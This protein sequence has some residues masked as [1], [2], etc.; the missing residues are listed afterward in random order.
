MIRVDYPLA[1]ADWVKA[2]GRRRGAR[3]AIDVLTG[4]R[5]NPNH[6]EAGRF[7]AS[8][9]S[10][11][12]TGPNDDTVEFVVLGR[13]YVRTPKN[14]AE[15]V[16]I[17]I[18]D[19]SRQLIAVREGAETRLR[20]ALAQ[21]PPQAIG[22]ITRIWVMTPEELNAIPGAAGNAIGLTSTRDGASNIYLSTDLFTPVASERMIATATD[23]AL[24]TD[25]PNIAQ[26]VTFD[27]VLAHEVAH[28]WAGLRIGETQALAK[29]I[30]TRA[31][32]GTL[33]E[34]QGITDYAR[35][36][37]PGE[38][39]AEAVGMYV[40]TGKVA[41]PKTADLFHALGVDRD[42]KPLGGDTHATKEAG[43]AEADRGVPDD[44]GGTRGVRTREAAAVD[45]AVALLAGLK[46]DESQHPRDE[47]GKFA[48]AGGGGGSRVVDHRPDGRVDAAVIA[49]LHAR[50]VKML[51]S[52]MD[53]EPAVE[54]G[55]NYNADGLSFTPLRTGPTF[56]EW[57]RE[58][59]QAAVV[60]AHTH[61]SGGPASLPD[62]L[63]LHKFD[64]PEGIVVGKEYTYTIRPPDGGWDALS[65]GDLIQ[66]W[67]GSM[68]DH[69]IGDSPTGKGNAE[70]LASA[71]RT[72]EFWTDYAHDTGIRYER[73]ETPR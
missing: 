39:F 46:F 12:L 29:Y 40:A 26:R 64:I 11:S 17:N 7:A 49:G 8:D 43:T 72:H 15:R 66:L 57:T 47:S 42:F 62:V 48:S 61:P 67:Q 1:N 73:T 37:G 23:I 68:R 45:E 51:T 3:A 4:E 44:G 54:H 33:E 65:R 31:P 35:D 71:A 28:Q 63:L 55:I 70:R 2:S 41:G 52:M 25:M 59:L 14:W 32:K 18:G 50:A 38:A 69:P 16:P 27:W 20:E 21:Y 10:G 36:G 5:F 30:E 24:H 60:N 19:K 56:T 58:D 22:G 9:S 6:D 13:G 34:M 53:S